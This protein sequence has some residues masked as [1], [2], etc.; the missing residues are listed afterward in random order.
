[1]AD[2]GPFKIVGWMSDDFSSWLES[3]VQT[4]DIDFRSSPNTGHSVVH[5]GLPF[6]TRRRPARKKVCRLEVYQ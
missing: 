1:M 3:E 2:S 4:L 6:V 5:S